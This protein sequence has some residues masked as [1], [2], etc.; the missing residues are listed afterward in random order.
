MAVNALGPTLAG[1]SEL[2]DESGYGLMF[3]PDVNNDELQRN[4]KAPVFYWVPRTLRLARQDMSE[5]KPF[6]FNMLK[7]AGMKNPGGAPTE[8]DMI[9]GGVLTFSVTCAPPP[10]VMDQLQKKLIEKYNGVQ[11]Y[12]WGIKTRVEPFFRPAIVMGNVTAVSNISPV[13]DGGVPTADPAAGGTRSIGGGYRLSGTLPQNGLLRSVATVRQVRSR[14]NID[15]WYWNMQGQG[16]GS[17]DPGGT[18]AYSALVGSIPAEIIW[19]A[20]H[21]AASPIIVIQNLKL[22]MWSPAVELTI[23]AKWKKVFEHFS[24]AFKGHYWF[25]SVDLK[26]EFNKMRTEGHIDVD[27]KVDQTIPGADKLAEQIDKRTDLVYTHLMEMAKKIIFDAPQPNVEAASAGSGIGPWGVGLAMKW[28]KDTVEYEET[29]H[30]TRQYA[31]LQ[32]HTI[33]SSLTGLADEIA[34]DA[35]KEKRYFTMVYLGDWPKKL[36][37]IIKPVVNWPK[38][39]QNWA[40]EPVAFLSAQIGYPDTSGSLMWK[41]QTFQKSDPPDST[42]NFNIEQ[43]R[44]EDV[45]NPPTNWEPDKTY[46]KRKVHLLE[47]QTAAENEFVQVQVDRNVIDLDP[48]PNGTLLNDV[49]V[50]VRADNAGRISVGPILLGVT[51]EDASQTV[52]VT[53][54]ATDASYTPT[55][56]AP[57]KFRWS[58]ANQDTPRFWAV[59]TG[60]PSTL[61][62][63]RYKV[64]VIVKGTLLRKGQEWEGPWENSTGNGPLTIH[65]PMAT[66]TGVN[67]RTIEIPMSVGTREMKRRREMAPSGADAGSATSSRALGDGTGTTEV[68]LPGGYTVGD[69]STGGAG[70]GSRARGMTDGKGS[71]SAPASGGRSPVG[72][73]QVEPIT[74]G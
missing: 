2:Y 7:F 25:A 36:A 10:G 12:F 8:D 11:D 9:A 29:Y 32:E 60:D 14:S 28:R 38:P 27:V 71:R 4:G 42:W 51:L 70:A 34:G 43:K 59:F 49:S 37:R 55:G 41:G 26:A 67:P 45:A 53:V 66:D 56:R 64:R 22:K 16:N 69:R 3:L 30:E 31:Y 54:E 18:N 21:G 15:P 62:H 73:L 63:F 58:F 44:K 35:A 48:E 17:I 19:Q 50:E 23:H 33:S 13:E 72:E 5:S 47:P 24:T 57:V 68:K 46:I 61:P 65:V 39:E 52:E 74:R 40:G 1:G 6:L 20:F